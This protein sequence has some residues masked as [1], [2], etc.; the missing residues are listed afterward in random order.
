M[1]LVHALAALLLAAV[2]SLAGL[3]IDAQEARQCPPLPVLAAMLAKKYD[4][5]PAIRA[6][7]PAGLLM[8]FTSREGETVSIVTV[9]QN[10]RPCIIA[11]GVELEYAAPTLPGQ[12]S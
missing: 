8:V 3:S 10:G 9:D 6:K 7:I 5:A 11:D 4:E 2:F 12:P 1:R